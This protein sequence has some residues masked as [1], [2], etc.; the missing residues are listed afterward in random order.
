MVVV[1]IGVAPYQ[2][3]LAIE[4][5]VDAAHLY[6]QFSAG[7][8]AAKEVVQQDLFLV[9]VDRVEGETAVSVVV[10]FLLMDGR[11]DKVPLDKRSVGQAPALE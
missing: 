3:A 8:Q 5:V 11:V 7:P 9:F 10:G 6:K 4:R 2:P 1:E